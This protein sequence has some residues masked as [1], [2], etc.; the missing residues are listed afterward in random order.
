MHRIN[1]KTTWINIA[2]IKVTQENEDNTGENTGDSNK[3]LN[4]KA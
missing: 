4:P 3:Y 2:P 1:L